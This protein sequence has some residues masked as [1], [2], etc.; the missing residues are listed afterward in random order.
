MNVNNNPVN[1]NILSQWGSAINQLKAADSVDKMSFNAKTGE[2][3]FSVNDGGDVKMLSLSM[4]ELDVPEIVDDGKIS[5]LCAKLGKGDL[6]NLTPQQVETICNELTEL[7]KAY[8]DV[9]AG[10]G[11][12]NVMFNLYALMALLVECGQKMRDAARDVRQAENE[13]V[14]TSIQNQ[15][16][17]QRTASIVG[18]IASAVV[19]AIQ[20]GWQCSN[21]KSLSA[22]IG[23]QNTARTE[24]GLEN[25]KADLKMAELQAK[26]QDAQ[27]HLEKVSGKT[28]LDI[29]TQVEG[30]FND[31]KTTKVALD[32]AALDSRIAANRQELEALTAEQNGQRPQLTEEQQAQV[33]NL[34]KQIDADTRLKAM[35]MAERQTLYRTQLKSELADIRNDPNATKAEIEYAEAYAANEIAQNSTPQQLA[36]DL[37][38]AQASYNQTATML[39]HSLAYRQGVALESESR[40]KGDMIM[41]GGNV[42]Q[43]LISNITEMVKAD[44]TEMGAEQQASQEMLDQAKDLFSQCQ[45]LIDSVVQLMQAVLQAEVQSMRDAIQA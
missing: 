30:T 25:A 31:S 23:Q 34:Q 6:T 16:D 22:G 9:L 43:G 35:P 41:A 15:A 28:G 32:D 39:E 11:S 27:A 36:D 3:T 4:P 20:I 37:A 14:Q 21:L 13:Q 10:N 7:V 33:N 29:K 44:A 24:M 40:I 26:P 8:A 1:P 38:A 19:G 17:Q 2:L 45:S 18:F 12:K 42:V 5:S